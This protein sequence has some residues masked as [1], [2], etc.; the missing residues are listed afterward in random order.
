MEAMVDHTTGIGA[1]L[2]RKLVMF[3]GWK[4]LVSVKF[5][6]LFDDRTSSSMGKD[7]RLK[8]FKEKEKH[9]KGFRINR[10]E[11]GKV[12]ESLC[13]SGTVSETQ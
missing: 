4:C 3:Q 5:N 1:G 8:E 2:K 9:G 11:G 6:G 7:Q 12:S 13:E 10:K